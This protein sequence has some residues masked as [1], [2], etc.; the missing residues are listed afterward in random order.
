MIFDA[1]SSSR[2]WITVT[3]VA[4]RV[5]NSASSIAVSPPPT[6]AIG[7]PRY[8]APSQVAQADTPRFCSRFSDAEAEPLR[9]RRRWRGS[10]RRRG[11]RAT[12]SRRGTGARRARPGGVLEQ[13]LGAEALGLLLEELHHLGPGDALRR[14]PGSSRR[15]WSASAGRRTGGPPPRPARAPRAPRRSRPCSRP[16][17]CRRSRAC[18]APVPPTQSPSAARAAR[19]ASS[20]SSSPDAVQRGEVVEAADV[21][22]AD[23]DLRDRVPSAAL[24]HLLRGAAAARR[25]R[26]RPSAA[27]CS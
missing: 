13:H 7:L 25:R 4:K 2:R 26:S 8:S 1:R 18:G 24:H 15:R 23:P 21:A 9:R 19:A 3:C 5:R 16:G 10:P 20:A 11:T 22:L 17:R 27:P 12:R 14:S 6:T